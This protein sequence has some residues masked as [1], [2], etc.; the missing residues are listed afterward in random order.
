MHLSD[1]LFQHSREGYFG[2]Y[3]PSWE[4]TREIN[5]KITLEWVQ[6]QFVTRVHILFYFL[7]DTNPQMTIK[8]TTFTHHPRVSSAL[9]S[10]WWWCHNR[11]LMTSQWP[12]NC[13][14]ITWIVISNSSDIYFIHS[15]IHGRWWKKYS[16]FLS[17]FKLW[18]SLLYAFICYLGWQSKQET[19]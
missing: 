11:L 12:D 6:K 2:V 7:Q 10:F 17:T 13:N 3:F 14:A 16:F 9:L 1:E 8:T 15:D 5:T 18:S 19:T 4:A